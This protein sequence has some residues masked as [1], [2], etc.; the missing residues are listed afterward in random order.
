MRK[1]KSI[2]GEWICMAQSPVEPG[3]ANEGTDAQGINNNL[4]VEVFETL[5]RND[6]N[7]LPTAVDYAYEQIWK[8]LVF[9]QEQK[10]QRLSDV[11]LAEK[12][13]VSRTPVRQA[14]DRLVQDGLVRSDPRRGFWVRTFSAQDIHE[15]YD[16]RGALEVLALRLAA[17]HLD[18]IDLKSQLALTHEVRAR[19]DQ[20]P[21]SLFLQGDFRLHTLFI[22][23]SGNGRL[24]HYLSTLRSQ[25][26][27]FQVKDTRNPMRMEPALNDH[28][29]ILLALLEP[30]IE[31][32]A[33]LLAAHIVRS[34]EFVL[35]DIFAEKES[36]H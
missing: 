22:R 31:K 36:E 3:E 20:H 27:M 17:P 10:E 14:L 30:D 23:A 18:P 35:A 29:Q 16:L 2:D 34:K 11:V 15:I 12:L 4:S 1:Q 13:G 21:V 9:A 26:S 5:W 33:K 32:A 25:F 8:Q 7:A 28:E 6:R 24:I 19:L